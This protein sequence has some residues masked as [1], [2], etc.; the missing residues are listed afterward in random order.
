MNIENIEIEKNTARRDYLLM[1][2][3]YFIW[4]FQPLYFHLKPD[5]DGLFLLMSRI[6]WGCI[7]VTA[8]VL[9]RGRGRALRCTGCGGSSFKLFVRK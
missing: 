9:L 7:W 1:L 6:L 4:G 8:L 2:T 3:C 5:I